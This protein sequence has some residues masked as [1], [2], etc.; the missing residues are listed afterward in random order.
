MSYRYINAN[1]LVDKVDAKT[2]DFINEM[3]CVFADIK[4]LNQHINIDENRADERAKVL[5][6]MRKQLDIKICFGGL[7]NRLFFFDMYDKIA[8]QLK[9][10]K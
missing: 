3:P 9:E 1:D 5:E 2:Q 6:E 4:P 10:Q 8:E 7:E